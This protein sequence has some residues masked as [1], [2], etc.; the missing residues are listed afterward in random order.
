[1]IQTCAGTRSCQTCRRLLFWDSVVVV[2]SFAPCAGV[3]TIILL[4]VLCYMQQPLMEPT[5]Q[6]ASN[7]PQDVRS[8][9]QRQLAR[10]CSSWNRGKCA[11]PGTCTFRHVCVTCRLPHRVKDCPDTPADSPWKRNSRTAPNAP[12]TSGNSSRNQ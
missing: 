6:D 4:N 9:P 12:S 2:E 5:N 1:M 3:W 10:I 8:R 11:Y 7:R